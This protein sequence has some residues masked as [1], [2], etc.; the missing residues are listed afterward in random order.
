MDL[1][2]GLRQ[3]M[4]RDFWKL[5]HDHSQGPRISFLGHCGRPIQYCTKREDK[6]DETQHMNRRKRLIFYIKSASSIPLYDINH[7]R[8]L[9]HIEVCEVGSRYGVDGLISQCGPSGFLARELNVT[10]HQEP[11]GSENETL[12]IPKPTIWRQR[13]G[14]FLLPNIMLSQVRIPTNPLIEISDKTPIQVQANPLTSLA[15]KVFTLFL[16]I[17]PDSDICPV[18]YWYHTHSLPAIPITP[19]RPS[20]TVSSTS[21]PTVPSPLAL[22]HPSETSLSIIT[23]PAVT[24]E[25]LRQA[26]EAG[27]SAVWLQPGSFDNENLEYARRE[28]KA[29]IGGDGGKGG[30]GWCVLVD[31]EEFAREARKSEKGIEKL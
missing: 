21:Y 27:V 5:R 25:V 8:E 28:F 30:E 11:N 16:Y 23:Q 24:R 7:G 22:S 9:G 14:H 29:G 18:L 4:R 15:I 17:I 26:K 6:R 31:G 19:S 2:Q 13:R 10:L 20:I 12:S 1:C 3:K